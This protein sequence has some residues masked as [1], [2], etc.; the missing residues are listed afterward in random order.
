MQLISNQV[1]NDL[2][3]E[4]IM[5]SYKFENEGLKANVAKLEQN[6]IYLR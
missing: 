6:V 5:N 1:N 2:K 3:S 4:R